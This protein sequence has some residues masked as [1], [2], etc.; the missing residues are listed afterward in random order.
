MLVSPFHSR[1]SFIAIYICEYCQLARQSA[2]DFW[3]FFWNSPSCPFFCFP[4]YQ[5][6]PSLF[7]PIIS[8]FVHLFVQAFFDFVLFG[9]VSSSR[10][11]H[12][13]PLH[14]LLLPT[15]LFCM[16]A[17]LAYSDISNLAF[18]FWEF[19]YAVFPIS[20][21]FFLISPHFA[22]PKFFPPP[23][24]MTCILQKPC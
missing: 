12:F 15:G 5:P 11:I 8:V 18:L 24:G 23:P 7:F 9:I 3:L 14:P 20:L 19:S 4:L 16:K 13:P 2:A 6:S 22:L 17:F 1:L 10:L 21:L